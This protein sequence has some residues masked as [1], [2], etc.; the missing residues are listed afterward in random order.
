MLEHVLI[1]VSFIV[2]L[3]GLSLIFSFAWNERMYEDKMVT[4]K[5]LY[6][7]KVT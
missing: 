5:T 4:V 6:E 1:F 2:L 3:L 7:R